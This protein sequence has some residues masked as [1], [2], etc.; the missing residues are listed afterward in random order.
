M[1]EGGETFAP[2]ASIIAQP[3]P[4]GAHLPGHKEKLED[5]FQTLSSGGGVAKGPIPSRLMGAAMR[6]VLCPRRASVGCD[7]QQRSKTS[8]ERFHYGSAHSKQGARQP[9]QS[10]FDPVSRAWTMAGMD[11][12]EEPATF[13]SMVLQRPDLLRRVSNIDRVSLELWV[14]AQGFGCLQCGCLY[15]R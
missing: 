7:N 12:T 10:I 4:D 8:K 2:V 5:L 1:L 6:A 3:L 13:A 9:S 14:I 11:F 15:V